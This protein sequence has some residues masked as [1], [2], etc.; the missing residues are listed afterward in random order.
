MNTGISSRASAKGAVFIL[1]LRRRK[2]QETRMEAVAHYIVDEP[3]Q[4]YGK[5][6]GRFLADV[7]SIE[8]E[9]G[10]GKGTFVV[11]SALRNRNTGYLAIERLP[12]AI[13]VAAEKAAAAA[14]KNVVFVCCDASQINE[15]FE[16][17]EVSRVYIN[18]CDPWQKRRHEKRR[19]THRD[20]LMRYAELLGADGDIHFKTD[21]AL[22]FDYTL[23]EL[24]A[25]SF[26]ISEICRDLHAKDASW[27][28]VTEYEQAW[29][30]KGA[31]IL[32]LVATV[33]ESTINM[34]HAREQKTVTSDDTFF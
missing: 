3:K 16:S 22:L 30:A 10:C 33:T 23:S 31:Q 17:R 34:L 1:R 14:L 19:L 4:L 5:W 13:V 18:F 12:E 20:F 26:R 24:H 15:I 27:N 25:T 28:I 8:L 21:N 32:R 29:T 9:L 2:N 6:N 11:E 7:E